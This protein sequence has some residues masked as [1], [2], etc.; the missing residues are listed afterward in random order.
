[1][2]HTTC[3]LKSSVPPDG[4]QCVS[5]NSPDKEQSKCQG[6]QKSP[7]TCCHPFFLV[8]LCL[9]LALA[10]YELKH[11]FGVACSG[12]W[13]ASRLPFCPQ[14]PLEPISSRITPPSV[15][16]PVVLPEKT[17]L[18][19]SLIADTI[20]R[21]RQELISAVYIIGPETSYLTRDGLRGRKMT[22]ELVEQSMIVGG[23]VSN[24]T[25]Q[26]KSTTDSLLILYRHTDPY[27]ATGVGD[28]KAVAIKRDHI[29][30]SLSDSARHCSNSLDGLIRSVMVVS[31]NIHN[32]IQSAID[33]AQL[34]YIEQEAC[35][36]ACDRTSSPWPL[37]SW[38]KAEQRSLQRRLVQT[39]QIIA[40]QKSA[41]LLFSSAHQSLSEVVG[42]LNS[43]KVK[44]DNLQLFNMAPVLQ[45]KDH[46]IGLLDLRNEAS[47]RKEGDRGR[48]VLGAS[49]AQ[50]LAN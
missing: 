27:A 16:D 48:D 46:L 36:E 18:G 37:I 20:E 33:A 29:P 40:R 11:M 43:L 4:S 35:S 1:M 17:A 32:I 34:M 42:R 31:A 19:T 3:T 30:P 44:T 12:S 50:F 45:M 22:S 28:M 39:E 10:V 2:V 15:S 14:P 6:Q 21:G 26:L 13:L 9:S 47:I 49:A 7:R 38:G 25:E 24:F 23:L 41:S 8:I 5:P